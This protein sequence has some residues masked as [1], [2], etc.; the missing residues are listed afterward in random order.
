MATSLE[1]LNLLRGYRRAVESG[2]PRLVEENL[3]R[4]V[5]PEVFAEARAGDVESQMELESIA[6]RRERPV[7]AIYQNVT[8]LVFI[9]QAESE[10][11][12]ERI[13]KA[14]PMLDVAI[15]A[16]GRVDLKGG[17]LSWVGTGWL[18][19]DDVIVTNRH[20]A[21]EFA[22]RE[23]DKFLFQMGVAQRM[24]ASLD[25]LQEI[26][27]PNQLV[28]DLVRPL[29]IEDSPGPD[30]A[31]FEVRKTSGDAAL[32]KPIPL[33]S[34]IRRKESVATIG[35]PAYD[36]RIP[37]PD[38]MKRIYGSVF[39]KKRLAPGGV[40]RVDDTLIWHNC[41]TLGGNSGSVVLDLETGEAMGLHFSGSFLTTNYAVRADLV[42]KL[43]DDV[44]AGRG[45]RSTETTVPDPA[46][47][48]LA[49]AERGAA[50]AAGGGGDRSV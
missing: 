43:L 39:D 4:G 23:G 45:G 44:R 27:N 42:K 10:I 32:A 26:D 12:E 47:H 13:K 1:Q 22:T 9:D 2:D 31:F 8:K 17:S 16:V 15:P 40:T 34:D 20:V 37:E 5:E 21:R 3:D 36:S 41:T 24:A 49:L 35:Y 14:R 33:S 38:L 46:R 11:W 30:V 25:F 18:V 19:A 6:M 28:F 50:G 7:L 48:G 29:H